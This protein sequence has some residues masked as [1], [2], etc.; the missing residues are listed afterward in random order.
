LALGALL[1]FRAVQHRRAA[2]IAAVWTGLALAPYSFIA[3][4]HRLPSR[5]TYLASAGLALLVGAGFV[6]LRDRV[7]LRWALA[8]AAIAIAVNVGILWTKKRQ[9]FL[10]RAAPT[11]RLIALARQ[12]KGPIYVR[13]FP[14][15]GMIADS[16]VRMRAP[17]ATLILDAARAAEAKA[18]FCYVRK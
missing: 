6:A 14:D 13:C 4:M 1:G 12:V 10:E 2:I 7:G 11:E 9:Q 17:G 18:E 16:A 15:P 8:A 5:H 3:Y